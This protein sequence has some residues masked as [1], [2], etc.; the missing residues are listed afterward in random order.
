MTFLPIVE[1][2]LRVAARRH[3]THVVRLVVALAAMLIG[4]FFFVAP[5][6]SASRLKAERTFWGLSVLALAYCLY[7]GRRSTADCLSQEKR[8]GTL[9]LLFLTDLKGYDVVLGKLAA[10]SLNGFYCLLAIVP[11][12]ALPLLVGGVSSGEFWRMVLVLLDSFLFSLAVGVFASVLCREARRALGLNFVL[13]V[14]LAGLPAGCAGAFAYL[15][16]SQ[17]L[18]HGLLYSCPAYP[19]YLCSDLR[20]N[21]QTRHFWCAVIMIHSLTWLLVAVTSW[22]VAWSWQDQ[23]SATR[24]ARWRERWREWLYG[25][26]AT[27]SAYRKRL[28]ELNPY[29]WLASRV[30]RKAIG[31]WIFLASVLGW[32]F[33]VRWRVGQMDDSVT[34]ATALILNGLVKVWVGVET[35]QRLGDDYQSGALELLLSTPLGAGGILRGQFLALRRQFLKPLLVV[36]AAELVLA[37]LLSQRGRMDDSEL[38]AVGLVGIVLFVLDT[39]A[40][41][42]VAMA[43]ALTSRSPTQAT[44]RTIWRVLMLPWILYAV[45]AVVAGTGAVLAGTRELG[46]KFYLQLWFWLGLGA[47]LA[48]GLPA[49]WQVRNRFQTLAASRFASRP[50]AS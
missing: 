20:Y 30:R 2:E 46:W 40:V 31:V 41:A 39:L 50:K 43:S 11:V 47:D 22:S 13:L 21:A 33:F 3:S 14:V 29:C 5:L 35:G 49:W 37:L 26:A 4:M 25:D 32:W 45:I 27:R 48:Y 15:S 23:S 1:R 44:V 12:L 16:Q 10:T 6:P 7:S 36:I 18:V 42:W 19:F 24:W 8:E 28:L 38:A 9:G 17:R 34:L